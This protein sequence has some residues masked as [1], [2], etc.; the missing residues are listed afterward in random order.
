MSVVDLRQGVEVRKIRLWTMGEAGG[1]LEGVDRN[2]TATSVAVANNGKLLVTT[3]EFCC[4]GP[5]DVQDIAVATDAVT[6]RSGLPAGFPSGHVR[7]SGDRSTVAVLGTNNSGGP[8]LLYRAGT[9]DFTNVVSLGSFVRDVDLDHAGTRAFVTPVGKLTD[10]TPA[11]TGTAPGMTGSGAGALHPF[12]GVAFHAASTNV[13]LLNLSTLSQVGQVPLGD[14]ISTAA[15]FNGIGRMDL[16]PDGRVLAVVTNNGFSVVEPFASGPP[17][18]VELVRNGDFARSTTGWQTFATP[19]PGY[20]QGG[21]TGGV[22]EFN[23]L[24]P[25]PDQSNQATVFQN[26]GVPLPS[27]ATIRAQFD[28]G[29]SSSVRKRVSVLLLDADFSDLSVCTFW[30]PP[31]SGLATYR[32]TSHTTRP[33]TNASIYFYAA[34]AG[35]DGGYN[36]LDNV[37]LTFDNGVA[38]DRTDC[39]DPTAPTPSGGADGPDLLINGDFASGSWASWSVFGT[40]TAQVSGGVFEFVRP[41]AAPP[42][43]VVLQPTGTAVSAGE[44]LTSTF[45]LG[46]SSPVRKRVTVLLHDAD[47]SDLSACTFWLEPGQALSPYTMRAFAT[48]AWGSATVSFYAAT[49]D[50]DGWA[51][52]DNVTLRRTPSIGVPGTE[53]VEPGASG[54]AP[55]PSTTPDAAAAPVPSPVKAAV[56]TTAIQTPAVAVARSAPAANDVVARFTTRDATIDLGAVSAPSVSLWSRL[57]GDGAMGRLQIS[58]DGSDWQTVAILRSEEEWTQILID[59]SASP[60]AV[61]RFRVVLDDA[62]DRYGIPA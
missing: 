16:S 33:W 46:N 58:V 44:I 41:T 32:M 12:L 36:R 9:D 21:V 56:P 49:V 14:S 53:Y 25:P 7:A 27:G 52:L 30:V 13:R 48:K 51:R 5:A 8:M 23:R 50:T 35:I 19:D 10:G 37:S 22:F 40:M 42:A 43:G 31:G 54:A 38:P 4:T 20:F 28:L 57:T 17:Q 24:P 18:Q 45:E 62:E 47:F 1:P 39:Y 55:G 59:L 26:T 6:R 2:N 61:V 34:T 11:V 15:L 3:K 29:N 60:G